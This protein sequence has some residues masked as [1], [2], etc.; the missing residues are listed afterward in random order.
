MEKTL[1]IISI[2]KNAVFTTPYYPYGT[3]LVFFHQKRV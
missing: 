1:R 2:M 3:K